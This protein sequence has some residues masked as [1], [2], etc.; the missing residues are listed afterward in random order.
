MAS[1]R[2]GKSGEEENENET[3]STSPEKRTSN[4]KEDG[5]SPLKKRRKVNH[6]Q[7]E[8]GAVTWKALTDGESNQHA[9]TAG[10]R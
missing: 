7:Y 8:K 2:T 1:N 10:D 9:Y 5:G 4:G 6:G 3:E